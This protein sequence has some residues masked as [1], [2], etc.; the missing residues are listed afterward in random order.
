MTLKVG[1][2]SAGA[3][4]EPMALPR[5]EIGS[6]A[7]A[8]FIQAMKSLGRAGDVIDSSIANSSV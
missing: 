1:V 4:R 2:E 7:G 5:K 3:L 6:I 8:D